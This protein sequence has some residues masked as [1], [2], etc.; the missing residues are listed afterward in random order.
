M[1]INAKLTGYSQDTF[2]GTFQGTWIQDTGYT[3]LYRKGG[4]LYPKRVY[5]INVNF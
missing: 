1:G 2:Q 4:I 5:P 3:P